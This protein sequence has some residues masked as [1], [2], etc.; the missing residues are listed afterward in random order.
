MW[1]PST[2]CDASFSKRMPEASLNFV[3]EITSNSA[4]TVTAR[5]RSAKNGAAALRTPMSIGTFPA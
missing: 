4:G 5:E 1:R 2:E 3:T